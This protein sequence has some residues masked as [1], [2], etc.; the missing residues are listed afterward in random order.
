MQKVRPPAGGVQGIY[1]LA[2]KLARGDAPD[3]ASDG[4][5]IIK[6]VLRDVMVAAATGRHPLGRK[7]HELIAVASVGSSDLFVLEALQVFGPGALWTDPSLL[8]ETNDA[9]APLRG[10]A[11]RKI[12]DW[13]RLARWGVSPGERAAGARSLDRMAEALAGSRVGKRGRPDRTPENALL[14]YALAVYR[15][16]RARMLLSN[17]SGKRSKSERVRAAARA[18]GVP[19]EFL[20]DCLRLGPDEKP[21]GRPELRRRAARILAA[22]DLGVTEG[23]VR[24]LLARYL[25]PPSK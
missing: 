21:Y 12:E 4:A 18:A 2:E 1:A 9:L 19:V 8:A 13:C 5:T 10:T 6:E 15:L 16:E 20:R 24:D 7:M 17:S 23:R 11:R 3:L 22:K 25:R 14:R